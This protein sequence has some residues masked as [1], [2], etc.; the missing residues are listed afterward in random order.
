VVELTLH[1]DDRVDVDTPLPRGMRTLVLGVDLDD[2][3]DDGHDRDALHA[4]AEPDGGT[5]GD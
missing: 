1:D 3:Y 2:P 4:A 5:G